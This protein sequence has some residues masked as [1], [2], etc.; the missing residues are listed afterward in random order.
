MSSDAEKLRLAQNLIN[1]LGIRWSDVAT[2]RAVPTISEYL[3]RVL[4]AAT[5]SQ[6]DKYASYW[7]RAVMLYGGNRLD[8][9]RVSDLVALQHQS[10]GAGL[11]RSNSRNGRHAG[12]GCVRAMRLLYRL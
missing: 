3:P 10:V 4:A 8:E 9:L 12:E 11:R 6:R 5:P 1:E 2:P 7:D